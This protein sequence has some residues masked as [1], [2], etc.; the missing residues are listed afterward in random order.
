QHE[1]AH[2]HPAILRRRCLWRTFSPELRRRALSPELR[3]RT[4]SAEIARRRIVARRWR[5]QTWEVTPRWIPS[6]RSNAARQH[7]N[8]LPSSETRKPRVPLLFFA[9]LRR[10]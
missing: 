6:Q 7:S 2:R 9:T 3:W 1:T 5:R 4:F 10:G 8:T